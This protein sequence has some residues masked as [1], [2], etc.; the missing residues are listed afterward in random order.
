MLR[1][2]EPGDMDYGPSG[3]PRRGV[4]RLGEPLCLGE[5][6]LRLGESANVRGLCLW[7]V[8]GQFCGPVCD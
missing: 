2:G 4:L 8:S 3:L 6:R 5:G 1:L 7:P